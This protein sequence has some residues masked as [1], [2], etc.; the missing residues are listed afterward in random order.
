MLR[1]AI[2]TSPVG[3]SRRL[4]LIVWIFVAIVVGLLAFAYYSFG[5]MSAARAYVGGEGLWSKAQKDA[6]L[7]LSRYVS[8]QKPQDYQAFQD[9]LKVSLGDRQARLEL[10]KPEPDLQIAAEGFLQGRNH[11]DDVDGMIRLYRNFRTV[12]ELAQAIA[13]WNA[14]D[15][16]MDRLITLGTQIHAAVQGTT[17]EETSRRTLLAQLAHI[18]AQLTPL[19]DEFSYALGEI[20]RR[21]NTILRF[22]MMVMATILLA[23]AYLVSRRIVQQNEHY[24][25]SLLDSENQLR[26]LLQFAP[27]PIIIVGLPEAKVTYANERALA[28]FHVSAG[29]LGRLSPENF[30]VDPDERTR[31][32]EALRTQGTVRDWEVQLQD[33]KGNRFWVLLS[34]QRLLLG[35]RECLLTALNNIDARKQA[36]EELR[37]RAFH[38]ELTG[39]PNRAMFMDSLSRTLHRAERK[40]GNFCI[41][42][43]DLD[44]FKAVNDNH[45]HRVG[46]LLLQ[47][48]AMRVRLCVREGDLVARIGGD[49]F[50]VLV[51]ADGQTGEAAHIARKIQTVLEPVHMLDGHTLQVT[52]SIGISSYPQDGTELDE[53][54]R[55]ADSAMYRVKAQGRNSSQFHSLP[56][57]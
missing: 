8:E 10:D 17:L 36:Q 18:N 45:G 41:L 39:L 23:V 53:L 15:T 21:T 57:G 24:Q 22:T 46:D 40:R 5:L 3:N 14:A 30:Y 16:H 2:A 1:N 52:A 29:E 42:F 35:G 32:L 54:L 13:V 4:L 50:V 55:N 49:E 28:Q 12:P 26:S 48:V 51:E 27:L 25:Q 9:A 47:E 56:E 37:H 19:E 38:D 34:S 43:I 11:P 44:H 20:S 7:A 6:V 31:V 33:N